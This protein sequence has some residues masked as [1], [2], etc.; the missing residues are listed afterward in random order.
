VRKKKEEERKMSQEDMLLEAAQTGEK[1]AADRWEMGKMCSIG[2]LD[3]G[4]M[5]GA[6]GG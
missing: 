6:G 3:W 4:G 1:Q 5:V 2:D